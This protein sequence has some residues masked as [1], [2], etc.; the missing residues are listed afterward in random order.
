MVSTVV[1]ARNILVRRLKVE[2]LKEEIAKVQEKAE[3]QN[4][5]EMGSYERYRQL[6]I[7]NMFT[8]FQ[9]WLEKEIR[10]L[11]VIGD[12]EIRVACG[13]VDKAIATPQGYFISAQ[14]QLDDVKKHFEKEVKNEMPEVREETYKGGA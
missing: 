13:I 12:G 14:A 3:Q 11:K 8:L 5:E 10:E 7:E 2:K 9:D 6:L 1:I 4:E